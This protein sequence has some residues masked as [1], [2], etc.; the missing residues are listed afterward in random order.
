MCA[1]TEALAID[2][3]VRTPSCPVDQQ[4]LSALAS[5]QVS[6]QNRRISA[7]DGICRRD[8]IRRVSRNVRRWRNADMALRWTAAGML[9]AKKGF[10]GIN[11]YWQLPVLRA[12]LK[13][14]QDNHAGNTDIDRPAKV[15]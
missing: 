11:A 12:A 8:T 9:E 10:R 15:A 13:A 2:Q 3:S 4:T 5:G 7:P 14:H 6:R 1:P